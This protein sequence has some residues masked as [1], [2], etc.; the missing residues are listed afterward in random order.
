M[1]QT[2]QVQIV[3]LVALASVTRSQAQLVLSLP[4]QMSESE[5]GF[6]C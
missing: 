6:L 4:F 1:L 3:Q 2:F 5:C